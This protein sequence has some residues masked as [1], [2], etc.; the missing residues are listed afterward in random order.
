[1]QELETT[2]PE[3]NMEGRDTTE[4]VE[5][6][7]EQELQEATQE[8]GARVE[9]SQDY[10]QAEVV[11]EALT[12]SVAS[13]EEVE[14]MPIPLPDPKTEVS[15]EASEAAVA[16]STEAVQV[17]EIEEV[18]PEEVRANLSEEQQEALSNLPSKDQEELLRVVGKSQ[19]ILPEQLAGHSGGLIY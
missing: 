17:Q 15:L 5:R 13:G 4:S 11:E 12:E 10:E 9:A 16:E 1:M 14:H 2:Q 7:E 3:E 6:V 8:P 19:R 18:S